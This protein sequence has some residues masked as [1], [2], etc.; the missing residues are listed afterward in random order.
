MIINDQQQGPF[1]LQQVAEM[2]ITPQTEVWTEGM[3]DWR[4]AGDVPDLTEILQRQEFREHMSASSSTPPPYTPSASST[5]VP[6]MAPQSPMSG[7]AAMP[8]Q[9]SSAANVPPTTVV[10]AKKSNRWV[11]PVAI[12]LV[13][14]V[15]MAIT[16]PSREDHKN[17]I[18]GVTHEWVADKVDGIAGDAIN[19]LMGSVGLGSMGDWVKNL[20]VNFLNEQLNN[21]LDDYFEVD[22][23]LVLTVG[24]YDLLG[25]RHTVSV[26][27]FGHVFTFNTED[28]DKVILEKLGLNMGALS[29]KSSSENDNAPASIFDDSD[30]DDVIVQ[31]DEPD[32]MPESPD[33]VGEDEGDELLDALGELADSAVVQGQRQLEKT[34]KEWAKKQIEKHLN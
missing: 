12:I 32:V 2:N 7:P 13:L 6:P 19:S 3:A 24:H 4:P 15:I 9:Q 11:W 22:N 30:K 1:T 16:C 21:F 25:K 23:Y 8:Y 10:P 20:G 18:K 5:P 34:A 31:D 14:L 33:A 17:A 26:G 28:I 27:A 29:D